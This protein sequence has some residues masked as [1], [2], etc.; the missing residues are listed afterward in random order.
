MKGSLC[1]RSIDIQIRILLFFLFLQKSKELPVTPTAHQ[2]LPGSR[3]VP[4]QQQQQ[5]NNNNNNVKEHTVATPWRWREKEVEMQGLTARLSERE[6][7]IGRLKEKL[8]EL[9]KKLQQEQQY[10][11][12]VRLA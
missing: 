12:K 8:R 3:S 10:N 9:T 7:E 4:L 6:R 2:L 5:H 1:T 11:S